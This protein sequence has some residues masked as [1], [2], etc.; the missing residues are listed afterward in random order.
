M[1]TGKRR[2][3]S[4]EFK[5]SAVKRLL[6]GEDAGAVARELQI[7]TGN[8]YNW[9]RHFGVAGRE[10]CVCLPAAPRA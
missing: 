1:S 2:V 6:A 7:P 4:R 8:L 10:R 5:V 3:Y 9:C